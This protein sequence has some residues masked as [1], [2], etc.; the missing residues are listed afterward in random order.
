MKNLLQCFVVGPIGPDGSSI[1]EKADYI[2]NSVIR[3]ALA[4]EYQVMRA[5]VISQPGLIM[6]QIVNYI[7]EA[8]LI[9][10]DLTDANP[11]VCYE[12]GLCHALRK[13][14]IQVCKSE[15]F[16]LPFDLYG[17]RTIPIDIGSPDSVRKAIEEIRRQVSFLGSENGKV[18]NPI[19][20]VLD[21]KSAG[22]NTMSG[23]WLGDIAYW[24]GLTA[25]HALGKDKNVKGTR[26]R[27]ILQES[28][29]NSVRTLY[30]V[31]KEAN[32]P[33][34]QLDRIFSELLDGFGIENRTA[35]PD[36]Q[37]S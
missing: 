37:S 3:E 2:M 18:E 22:F 25:R 9:V 26:R 21:A 15:K 32:I 20:I 10:A 8:D 14:V 24:I 34:Q 7:Y 1:R 11:N 30:F 6:T 23:G 36:E 28:V 31:A 35:N 19:S 29:L 12:L 5:D 27:K 33:R 16:K 13:P 17:V 4:H